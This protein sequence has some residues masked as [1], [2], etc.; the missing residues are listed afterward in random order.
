MAMAPESEAPN[1]GERSFASGVAPRLKSTY[2]FTLHDIESMRLILRGD[3]VIDWH[4]LNLE[5][6]AQVRAFISDHELD[7]D[8]P[9]DR[10]YIESIKSQAIAY[11]RR[12]FAFAIPKPVE[13]A[14]LEELLLIASSHGHR[15]Q[16]ACTILKVM[17]IINHL[18]GRELLFR[19]PVSDRDLFHL[20]EEKVYRIVGT[21]LS[22]GFPITEFVGGRKNLDS[23]YTKLLSK[24]ESTAVAVYDKLRF[25]I[26]TRSR[27]DL[28][29]V[30][31]YLSERLFPFNY[32]V[33]HQ[34]TNTIFHFRSYCE[35][36]PRLKDMVD[37][38][39]GIID[40]D[41]T[42]G[43]NRFSAPTYR[44]IHFVSDVP[45][46][47]P[48]SFMQ[49]APPGSETLGPVVYLLCEFQLVDA[50]TEATNE[51]GD[52]SHGA[53]KQRQRDAVFRRLRLGSREPI[54]PRN[55]KS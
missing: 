36:H 54:D 39:Q 10:A 55:R 34:S 29:P 20:V 4:R 41:L 48:A 46:R 51:A 26:V 45:V 11:L 38:F 9:D 23:T 47:V 15:Q 32:V 3:S 40:D 8:D 16:C 25:R 52:A 18:A 37:K 28:L 21:M 43:D 14:S 17:H 49:L 5:D 44:V 19:L 12:N 7:P 53:Y 50:D 27:E 30:L 2:D 6:P 22:E 33:P 13:A 31:L 35:G 42:P 24:A 1:S